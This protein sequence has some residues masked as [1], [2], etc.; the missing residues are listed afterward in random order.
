VRPKAASRPPWERSLLDDVAMRRPWNIW[1]KA[2]RLRA[3]QRLRRLED[4]VTVVIVCWNT[5]E[6]VADVLRAVQALSP[7]GTRVVVVDNGSTDGSREMLRAWSGI[8]TLLLGGNS[9]HGVALDLALCRVATT[10]AVTLD[11]DALPLSENWLDPAVGPV[12]SGRAVVAGLRSSRDFVHPVYAAVDTRTFVQRR[13]SFQ[14]Y[15]SP[16]V[17]SEAAQWGVDAWDTGELL[18]QRLAPEEVTFVEPSP[19]P[20]ADLPGMT[21]GGVVYHHGGVSRAASGGVSGEALVGWRDAC[22]R[23]AA[24]GTGPASVRGAYE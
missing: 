15:V 3:V 8:D 14:A 7:P 4:G 13:L 12:R 22:T 1:V 11:S 2:Q 18:T 20:V 19:N 6:V 17:D 23:I 9:G 10:V 16:G 5:R 21:A 24:A